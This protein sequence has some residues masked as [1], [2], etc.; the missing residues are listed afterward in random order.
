MIH[1]SAENPSIFEHIFR[2]SPIAIA[3]VSPETGIWIKTNPAFCKMLG[4][5]EEELLTRTC[6]DVTN[7]SDLAIRHEIFCELLSGSQSVL[8]FEKRYVHKNGGIVWAS[9]HVSLVRNEQTGEPLHL[10]KQAI[11]ITG[12]K[13]AEQKLLEDEELHNLILEHAQDAITLSTPDGITLYAS[14]SVRHLLGYEPQEVIGR[15]NL[16]LYHPDDMQELRGNYTLVNISLQELSGYTLIL[17]SVSEGIFGLDNEG[18]G[19]FVN[20]AGACM[21]GCD[22]KQF[23]G[24]KHCETIQHTRADGSPYSFGESPIYKT[25]QDGLPRAANE[26]IFWRTDGSSF[27]V[28]YRIT[29]IID[30]GVTK[31]AVIVFTDITNEKEILRAKESAER[32]DH[33]KSEFLAIMSHELLT[34]MNGVIGMTDLLLETPLTEEQHDYAEIIRGSGDTLLSILNDILDFSKIEAGKMDL[35]RD[36][37]DLRQIMESVNEMFAKRLSEKDSIKLT[38]N[39][40]S[41]IPWAVMGDATR[42]RQVLINLVGNAMKFTEEGS[43]AVDVRRLP[44]KDMQSFM[45]EF[46]VADTGIGIPE[47]KL[48]D[49]FHSFSQLHP[50]VNRKYG[51]TGLGL[52]ICKKLVELMGGTISCHSV[53][54]EGSTFRFTLLTVD[55]RCE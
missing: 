46:A 11:D 6:M 20:P 50:S 9:L 13:A 37:V 52:A 18:K 14:T 43:V 24:K 53:E 47:D 22:P 4:Y 2:S 42:I 36:P 1:P 12:K 55:L 40:D 27:L 19:I 10:I 54:G 21:L 41:S 28:N 31:G 34:P 23:T 49:L 3:I 38:Y 32:A 30:K 5:T 17:N 48:D 35:S 29:P 51:G 16:E 39:I 7:A 44:G 15:N 8:E 26:E 33:A 45:L 25:I